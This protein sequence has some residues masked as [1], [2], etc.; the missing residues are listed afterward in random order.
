[1]E[2]SSLPN[3]KA[4]PITHL[5]RMEKSTKVSLRIAVFRARYGNIK[6]GYQSFE[7]NF[8]SLIIFQTAVSKIM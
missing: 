5:D 2:E 4:S 6:Q 7:S 8:L 1:M 3:L